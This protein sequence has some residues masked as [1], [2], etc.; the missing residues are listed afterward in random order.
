MGGGDLQ[1]TAENT[2]VVLRHKRPQVVGHHRQNIEV[3]VVCH[4]DRDGVV[5]RAQRRVALDVQAGWARPST[6]SLAHVVER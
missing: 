3:V 1:L 2:A 6:D 5:L 4:G